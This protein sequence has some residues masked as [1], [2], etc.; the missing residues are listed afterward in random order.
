MHTELTLEAVKG[1]FNHWRAIKKPGDQI[2][3]RLWDLARKLTKQY[4]PSQIAYR[5]R[6]STSQYK[7]FTDQNQMRQC[8]TTPKVDEFVTLVPTNRLNNNHQ[9]ESTG[10]TVEIKQANGKVIVLRANNQEAM[11]TVLNHI[12]N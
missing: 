6:L 9:S 4:K 11:A 5:L 2:P 1:E 7:C 3:A 10:L 8:Q 12:M